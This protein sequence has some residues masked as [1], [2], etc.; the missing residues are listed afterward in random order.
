MLDVRLTLDF[1]CCHCHEPL[2]VTVECRGPLPSNEPSRLRLTVAIP[3]P[4]CQRICQLYFD[5]SGTVHA[6][7]PY[8]EP[9]QALEPSLN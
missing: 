3:C 4:Y 8:R 1:A 9:Q 6:V 7:E 5:P 2:S